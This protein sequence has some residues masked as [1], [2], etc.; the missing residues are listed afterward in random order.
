[1]RRILD[2]FSLVILGVMLLATGLA[3]FGP[4]PLPEKVPTHLDQLGQ[5]A[6]YTTSSSYEI[7]PVIAV[8]VYLALTVV[9]AYS[10]LAKHAAQQE[11]EAGPPIE[12]HILKLIVW[13]KAELMGVFTCMQ[14]SALHAARHPDDPFS[15]WSAVMWM[16]IAA[17]FATVAWYVTM[18]VKMTHAAEE[19]VTP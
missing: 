4:N 5:P 12:A 3:I 1:M 2:F 6:A 13:I 9:A 16:L 15:M 7:L 8:V 18:M 19:Q 10:S 11:P 14:L 17:I